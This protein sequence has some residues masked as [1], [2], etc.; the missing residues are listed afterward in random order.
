MKSPSS[1]SP[2]W[3]RT[4]GGRA[5]TRSALGT[6]S[7]VC[8]ICMGTL[9]VDPRLFAS[10]VALALDA[11]PEPEALRSYGHALLHEGHAGPYRAPGAQRAAGQHQADATQCE[12]R[13]PGQGGLER[14]GSS[15]RHPRDAEPTNATTRAASRGL[16]PFGPGT[17]PAI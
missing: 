10:I 1:T 15:R 2:A 3:P 5:S 7:G 12:S 8:S 13:H 11:G 4:K 14:D 16:A 17:A 6:R 9:P